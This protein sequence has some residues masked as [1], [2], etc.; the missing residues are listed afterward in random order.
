[1]DTR[2][3]ERSEPDT[4]QPLDWNADFF[5]HPANQMV[6]PLVDDYGQDQ[7]FRRFALYPHLFWHDAPALD[8]DAASQPIERQITWSNRREDVV[9]LVQSVAGMHDPVCNVAVVGQQEKT[10]GISVQAP[11]GVDPFRYV[12]EIHHRSSVTFVTGRGDVSARFVQ[13][14]VAGALAFQELAVDTDHGSN[15]IGFCAELGHDLAID[16][17]APGRD[18]F[19]CGAA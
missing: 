2:D 4:P 17:D 5:H 3:A 14:Q 6:Y 11:N 8:R 10:F 15:R 19:F 13:Q 12:H 7:P 9:F 16:A 1:L 18:Q